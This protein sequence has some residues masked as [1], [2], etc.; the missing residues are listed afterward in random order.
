MPDTAHEFQEVR[1]RKVCRST[2]ARE[3][4]LLTLAM[5]S[6]LAVKAEKDASWPCRVRPLSQFARHDRPD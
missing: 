1:P 4:A 3:T 5:R 2:E 6:L